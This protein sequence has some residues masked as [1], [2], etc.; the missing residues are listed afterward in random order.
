MPFAFP[1][2]PA[3]PPPD[4]I[5]S[6]VLPESASIETKFLNKSRSVL[7]I[8]E[9]QADAEMT[10]RWEMLSYAHVARFRQFWNQVETRESFLLPDAWWPVAIPGEIK[11]FYATLSPTGY[12]RFR[13]RPVVDDR[14]FLQPT[15]VAILK[16][17]ID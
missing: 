2:N 17:E 3:F 7:R 11:N 12:W 13:E 4:W 1:L 6:P 10:A 16:G 5:D 15:I 8:S 14:S 9:V